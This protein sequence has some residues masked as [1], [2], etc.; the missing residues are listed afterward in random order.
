MAVPDL[1]VPSHVQL[2]DGQYRLTVHIPGVPPEVFAGITGTAVA[3]MSTQLVDVVAEDGST[4]QVEQ[5]VPSGATL[6][7]TEW[8]ADTTPEYQRTE[9][10]ALIEH[11]LTT[12]SAPDPAPEPITPPGAEL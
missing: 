5:L 11:A 7:T 8:D 3:E 4:T 2:P 1:T 12:A 9:T 10:R 6:H